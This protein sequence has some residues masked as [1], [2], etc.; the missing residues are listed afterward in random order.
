MKKQVF[1]FIMLSIICCVPQLISS[2]W[3]LLLGVFYALS[4]GNSF[5]EKTSQWGGY[6]LKT[7]V[8]GL[9]FGINISVLLK[10]GK[11]N[12]GSTSFFVVVVLGLGYLIGKLLKID[13]KI[14]LLIS[15]GT[16]IC[17]GSAIAAVGLCNKSRLKSVIGFDWNSFFI[18]RPCPF[19]FSN[20]W[21]LVRAFPN[22]VWYV[23]RN[24]NP[25]YEFGS[26]CSLK[27]R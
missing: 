9:G 22:A 4:L 11:E 13:K 8:I 17:G 1:A 19:R 25:R 24:R 23:G 6:L 18:E 10:A 7:S 12:I 20:H 26:G 3:A 15:A 16:A 14:T 2:S 21:A 5:K 27:I